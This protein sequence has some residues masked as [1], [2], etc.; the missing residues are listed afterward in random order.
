MAGMRKRSKIDE[1][2]HLYTQKHVTKM[3]NGEKSKHHLILVMLTI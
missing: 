3:I 2:S 1:R